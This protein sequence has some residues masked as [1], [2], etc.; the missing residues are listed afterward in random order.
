ME[1][2]VIDTAAAVTGSDVATETKAGVAAVPAELLTTSLM[3]S[4][5]DWLMKQG[6]RPVQEHAVTAYVGKEQGKYFERE[7]RAWSGFDCQ[8]M[9]DAS[10]LPGR[11]SSGDAVA[12]KLARIIDNEVRFVVTRF[13]IKVDTDT[14]RREIIFE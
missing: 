4:Q 6:A 11:I 10:V 2:N 8:P 12:L 1:Q 14:G 7:G 13:G 5:T 9:E 3:S